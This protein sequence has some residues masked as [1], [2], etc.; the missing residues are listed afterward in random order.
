MQNTVT[1][2]EDLDDVAVLTAAVQ[3]F[4]ALAPLVTIEPEDRYAHVVLTLGH[5]STD[6]LWGDGYTRIRGEFIRY[7]GFLPADEVA[8]KLDVLRMIDDVDGQV[9]RVEDEGECL[10]R[11]SLSWIERTPHW[12]SRR[13]IR[14]PALRVEY[15]QVTWASGVDPATRVGYSDTYVYDDD[16]REELAA[17]SEGRFRQLGEQVPIEW[18]PPSE[19]A[20]AAE[21]FYE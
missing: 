9:G 4:P 12:W 2:S 18:M 17:L 5:G 15:A 1:G 14:D 21:R 10:V 16:V 3:R 6:V 13:K 8:D 11:F 7:E 19:A 20:T